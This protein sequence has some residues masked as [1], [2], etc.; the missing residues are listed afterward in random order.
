MTQRY[1]ILVVDDEKLI[2]W[3]IGERLGSLGYEVR[4]AESGEHALKEL[5][6]RMPDLV[7]LDVRMPGV[8]GVATLQR[9]RELDPELA[10]IMMSAHSTVDEAVLAMKHGAVDF[11]VKPFKL[12]AMEAALGRAFAAMQVRRSVSSMRGRQLNGV[13]NIVGIS[14]A[15]EQVRSMVA[16]VASSEAAT[17]LIEG[18]SGTGKEVVA[19]AVHFASTRAAQPFLQVNCAALPEGLLES[20]MY[21]HERGAFTNAHATK[22]GLFEM[23]SGGSIL[24]DEIGELPSPGQAKLL[25]FLENKT[26]RRIGGGG[27]L[28]ADVRVVAA[29]NVDLDQR[30][31]DGRF[32]TDLFFRLNVVRIHLPPLRD[33]PEDIPILTA[34][35]I[36]K[37][38]EELK[39]AVGGVANDALDAMMTYPWPGNVRELRNVVERALILHTGLDEIRFEHLPEAIR[40][41]TRPTVVVPESA[42]APAPVAAPEPASAPTAAERRPGVMELDEAEKKLIAEALAQAGGNQ[43]KASRIL[44]ITRDTLRYRMKKHGLG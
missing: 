3:S 41:G 25:R 15:I 18:E 37:Y 19:R 28:H 23:A 29:T 36:A 20:E 9:A 32:R 13:R 2:R 31:A 5:I 10:V 22:R 42:P 14:G 27:E 8:S 7:L 11:L 33:H 34:H 6:E 40:R 44:A 24:L 30:T 12:E 16:R 38:S 39:H 1:D 35:F 21:G 4:L 17:V 26:F 43:S